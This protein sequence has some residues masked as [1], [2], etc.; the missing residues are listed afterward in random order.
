MI[1]EKQAGRGAEGEGEA[2]SEGA[3]GEEWAR[4]RAE[5]VSDIDFL[6]RDDKSGS[7]ALA[8][9]HWES[10]SLSIEMKPVPWKLAVPFRFLKTAVPF[11]R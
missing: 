8:R 3:S 11:S 10:E 9:W 6:K 4:V 5:A 7:L 1:G 2:G